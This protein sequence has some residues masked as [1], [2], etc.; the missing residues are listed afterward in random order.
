[1]VEFATGGM[2]ESVIMV[3]T[4]TVE[5]WRCTI[6]GWVWF[7]REG[8]IPKRC[9]NAKCRKLYTTAPAVF[10]GE[11]KPEDLART[12]GPT[13]KLTVSEVDCAAPQARATIADL[14]KL[15]ENIKPEPSH[16]ET[17]A[18]AK[19]PDCP[20]CDSPLLRWNGQGRSRSN[21]MPKRNARRRNCAPRFWTLSR[22]S[23][24]LR[25]P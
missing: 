8:K 20:V 5:V 18:E 4:T 3:E 7:K 17:I 23:S 21:P 13:R 16:P 10:G 11:P 24:K 1:M 6:C 25:S 14:R 22:T 9:P 19:L 15:I 12:V 2:V